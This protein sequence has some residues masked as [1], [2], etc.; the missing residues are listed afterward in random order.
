MGPRVAVGSDTVETPWCACAFAKGKA[1]ASTTVI[2][3]KPT[4]SR[5]HRLEEDDDV[6]FVGG[7]V[8]S[9]E[10]LSLS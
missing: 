4:T 7:T 6:I 1:R 8:S 3:A 2:A 10:S 5:R 9:T